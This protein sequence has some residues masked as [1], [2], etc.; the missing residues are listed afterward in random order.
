MTASSLTTMGYE[1]RMEGND[2]TVPYRKL[3]VSSDRTFDV[4]ETLKAVAEQMVPIPMSP[5]SNVFAFK[6]AAR[7]LLLSH[8]GGT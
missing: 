3:Q 6:F 4:E 7:S 2:T 5:H 1:N 8:C